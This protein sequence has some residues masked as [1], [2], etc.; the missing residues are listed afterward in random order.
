VILLDANV[1]LRYLTE[2]VTPEDE[3][4]HQTATALFQMIESGQ[5]SFT[6]SDAVLAEVIYILSAKR[7]YGVPRLEVTKLLKP[8]LELRG[9]RLPRKRSILHALD[10]WN[11]RPKLSFVDALMVVSAEHLELPLASFDGEVNRVLG[12][13]RWQPVN[14]E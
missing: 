10:V 12:H 1:F 14:S 5:E 6:T 9:C 3:R 13:R 8:I 11:S 4:A 7:H 2:P